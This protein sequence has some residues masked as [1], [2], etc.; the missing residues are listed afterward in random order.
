MLADRFSHEGRAVRELSAEGVHRQ[1]TLQLDVFPANSDNI[2][3]TRDHSSHISLLESLNIRLQ[4][5]S[6][7]Y[8]NFGVV[9]LTGSTE[10]VALKAL[11]VLAITG[12]AF[13]CSCK[14]MC[15]HVDN[16]NDERL[17]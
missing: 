11:L 16:H 6:K 12:C 4:A 17:G 7:K 3:T 14:G 15:V 8:S 9:C 10:T 2:I 5:S 1:C 13:M